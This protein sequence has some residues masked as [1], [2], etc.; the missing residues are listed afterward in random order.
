[1]QQV[2]E[3]VFMY[4]KEQLLKQAK[5]A[6]VKNN[7]YFVEDIVGYLPCT[8]SSFYRIFPSDSEE[9]LS[10]KE[11]LEKN[12]IKAKTQ[13]RHNL[14]LNNTNPTAQLALYRMIATPEERAAINMQ[15]MDITTNG[16]DVTMSPVQIEVIDKR[17]QV[18]KES[19]DA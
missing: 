14:E 17:E 16:K 2:K 7:L 1:L 19:E 12:R 18:L 3:E 9:F 8:R 5:Q 13:I 4:N 15:K 10:L 6:I 11:S